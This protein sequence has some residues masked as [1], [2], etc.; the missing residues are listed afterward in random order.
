MPKFRSCFFDVINDFCHTRCGKKKGLSA[1]SNSIHSLRKLSTLGARAE[2][3]ENEANEGEGD[4]RPEK[5]P[6][7]HKG[8]NRYEGARAN[9]KPKFSRVEKARMIK[10]SA[11]VSLCYRHR[12]E[13]DTAKEKRG[14]NNAR[15]MLSEP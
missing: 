1:V 3:E 4:K 2:G 12:G 15:K 13:I 7:E 10:S 5:T 6:I 14:E 11:S 8:E 9:E